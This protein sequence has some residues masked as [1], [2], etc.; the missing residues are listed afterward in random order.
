VAGKFPC[1]EPIPKHLR[2]GSQSQQVSKEKDA[3]P[4]P[5]EVSPRKRSL[6]H[7]NKDHEPQ[8][9]VKRRR[10]SEA[11]KTDSYIPSYPKSPDRSRSRER[12]S[13]SRGSAPRSRRSSASSL[14]SLE[15]ALLGISEE[16]KSPPQGRSPSSPPPSERR[17]DTSSRSPQI[18]RRRPKPQS[19]YR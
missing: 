2:L 8:R 14:N 6:N 5:R 16:P 15:A 18:R 1:G 19:A 17:G 7:E 10:P 11:A 3:P 9:A 4:G 13:E 12:R